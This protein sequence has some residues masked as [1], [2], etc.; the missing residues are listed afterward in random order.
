[1]DRQRGIRKP[2]VLDA[3]LSFRTVHAP[4]PDLRPYDDAP[5]TT[6]TCDTSGVALM[7]TILRTS[8]FDKL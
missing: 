2:K 8:P 3:A 1:M 6:G 7:R 4:R 5:G